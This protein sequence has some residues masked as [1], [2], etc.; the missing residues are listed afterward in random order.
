MKTLTLEDYGLLKGYFEYQPY[1]I[2][3]YSLP[4]IIAWSSS[5]YHS[6]YTILDGTVLVAT[7][8]SD[9][10]AERYLI[11]PITPDPT[12]TAVFLQ[13]LVLEAGLERIS[14]VPEDYIERAG[15][16]SLERFFEIKEQPEYEDYIYLTKDLAELKGNRYAKKRNLIHQFTREFLQ[17]NRV[18]TGPLTAGEVPECLVFLEDWCA[19]RECEAG[20]EE[21]V[22]C[23]KAA[24]IA[25]LNSI[26]EMDWRGL[27]VRID[28]EVNAFAIVS[29]LT[30][31]MGALNFEKA[32]AHVKGLYQFLDNQCAQQLFNGYLYVNK[33][34]DMGLSSLAESKRSYHPVLKIKSYCLRIKPS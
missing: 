25:A 30:P 27:W 17:H 2:S 18:S 26:E 14:F 1:R 11:M 5:C 32:Y 13:K 9:D 15:Y 33:E 29:H 3:S 16:S 8:S 31:D 4:S 34:S 20:Q 7:E 6:Y 22:A 12:P 24:V 10:P 23:E 21:N 28:G 19:Q